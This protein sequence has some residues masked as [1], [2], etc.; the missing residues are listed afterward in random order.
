M[1]AVLR[2]IKGPQGPAE[3]SVCPGQTGYGCSVG[4][5]AES[6]Q[7]TGAGVYLPPV[8]LFPLGVAIE[9]GEMD[10]STDT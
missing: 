5:S 6:V 10:G 7:R 4:H 9:G 1:R 2:T 3:I 8:G